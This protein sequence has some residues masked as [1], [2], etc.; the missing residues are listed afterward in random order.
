MNWV[1]DQ[2]DA[3]VVISSIRTDG[4]KL[5]PVPITAI[6]AIAG[7]TPCPRSPPVATAYK[8]LL[9][10][11]FEKEKEKFP[12]E[13]LVPDPTVLTLLA[14]AEKIVTVAPLTPRPAPTTVP[15]NVAVVAAAR[16]NC[17]SRT[18]EA[19]AHLKPRNSL[20]HRKE[21][22]IGAPSPSSAR[23]PGIFK[24]SIIV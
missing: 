2:T 6:M 22:L 5:A 20:I 17:E 1:I 24:A 12:F 14:F 13:S 16:P 15:E 4:A 10:P 23:N 21:N 19:I 18:S 11:G 7:F 3:T 8:T 9:P